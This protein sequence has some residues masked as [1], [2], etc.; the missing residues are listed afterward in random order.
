METVV[1]LSG[2]TR[3]DTLECIG[4]SFGPLFNALGFELVEISLR[5]WEHLL[6]NVRALN[7][8]KVKFVFSF[9]SMGMDMKVQRADG[10]SFELWPEL[11]IP[12]LS[13]HGDSPAYFF[14]RHI[15]KNSNFVS[16]YG[17][18][19]H[20]ELR[21][22]LPRLHGPVATI[23]PVALNEVPKDDLDFAAKKNGTLLFLKNGKDPAQLRK[24][25]VSWL[26]P[27]LAGAIMDLARDIEDH[28]DDVAGNYIDDLVL[29]YFGDHGFDVEQMVKLRLFFIAQLDD[30]ARAVKCTRMADALADFPVE[31]RGN[32]WSHFDF[33]GRKATY[34][35]ECDYVKS[36]GL[37]RSALGTIDMSPNTASLPHD[38]VMRAYG[39]HTLCLTNHQQFLEDLPHQERLTFRFEKDSIQERVADILAHKDEALEMGVE[40]AEAYKKKHPPEQSI[41]NM[42]D[43]AS[44]VRLNGLPQRPPGAQDFFVW[45][46]AQI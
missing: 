19:E 21:K 10:T 32:N 34:I 43:C 6:D 31:I 26:E 37:I 29:R 28:L 24:L 40:V 8:A 1:F 25:W 33:S 38:R 14:D 41:M 15:V 30:Y 39:A 23:W 5:D 46:P 16:I 44:L 9:V 20:C 13:I 4:R 27:R 22:R 42:L 18:V 36:I 17:F 11:G 35:D 3:G 45:P 12:F 7:L 2:I